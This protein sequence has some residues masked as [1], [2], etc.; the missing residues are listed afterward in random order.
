MISN[1]SLFPSLPS[2]TAMTNTSRTLFSR[3]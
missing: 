3:F 2:L 1:L